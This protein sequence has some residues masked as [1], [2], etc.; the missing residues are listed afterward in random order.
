[1]III[2][3]LLVLGAAFYIIRRRKKAAIEASWINNFKSK[4]ER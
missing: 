2:P 1:M 3:I 4:T